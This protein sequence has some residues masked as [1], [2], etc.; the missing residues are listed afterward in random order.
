RV[1]FPVSVRAHFYIRLADIE[2]RLCAGATDRL[3]L[4]AL[5]GAAM[6]ARELLLMEKEKLDREA[7]HHGLGPREATIS[8]YGARV[9]LLADF[10]LIFS[11]STCPAYLVRIHWH[12]DRYTIILAELIFCNSPVLATIRLFPFF[13]SV[14]QLHRRAA[15][16]SVPPGVAEHIKSTCC[17]DCLDMSEQNYNLLYAVYAWTNAVVVFFSGFLVD[18]LGNRAGVIAFS[19]L[20]LVGSSTFAAGAHLRGTDY[21]LPVMLLG[22]L[23]FGAGNG[24]LTVVQNRLVAFWFNKK[25][26]ALAFGCVL[27]FSRCGSVLNFFLTENIRDAIG[28]EWTLWFGVG[29]CLLGF[30]AAGVVSGLDVYGVRAMGLTEELQQE[31]RRFWLLVLSIM[32]YYNGVFPFVADASQF[33]NQKYSLDDKVSAYI[34]G[35]VYDVSML[36]SPFLGGLI[37][38]YL[39]LLCALLTIPVF[40]LLAFTTVYPLVSTL[41]LGVTYSFAAASMWPSL[42][43]VVPR[44]TLGTALGFTTSVQMIGIGVSNVVVGRI[45]GQTD[46]TRS[47]M[48]DRWKLVMLYLL[49][50][51]IA[52]VVVTLLLNAGRQA[53]SEPQREAQPERAWINLSKTAFAHASIES[54]SADANSAA[55]YGVDFAPRSEA[56]ERSPLLSSGS[57]S[58]GGGITSGRKHAIN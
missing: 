14:Q 51:V 7:G 16:V 21:L 42:P 47:V 11:A 43:L 30:V 23:L 46:S 5:I 49:G 29:L 34:T 22:R 31:S 41:W 56:D 53:E 15:A 35:A 39:A 37:R 27:A 32:F 36:L 25:E 50:N 17:P 52:A 19:L 55:G 20:C 1:D 9:H 48:L 58:S 18:K 45:L 24:S 6:E 44:A 26:L 54:G 2:E 38:G 33:I 28:L 57:S 8:L 3:Q 10:R 4:S 13:P 40:G 12:P